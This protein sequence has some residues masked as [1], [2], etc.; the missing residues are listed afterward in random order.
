MLVDN[1]IF[2][3][4]ACCLLITWIMLL[5]QIALLH[6]GDKDHH[7]NYDVYAEK[8]IFPGQSVLATVAAQGH[9]TAHHHLC[10]LLLTRSKLLKYFCKK[11]PGLRLTWDVSW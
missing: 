7:L 2:M 6:A 5:D 9:R 10:H 11:L 8:F 3:G 4:D 1:I